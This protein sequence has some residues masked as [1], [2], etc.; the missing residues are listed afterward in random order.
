MPTLQL[1]RLA[2][3]LSRQTD[4]CLSAIGL[5]AAH[6]PVLAALKDGQ[7]KTQKELATIAGVEQPSMAQLLNR[8]ERDGLIV[9]TASQNDR[10]SSLVTL[11]S[12]GCDR[13]EPGRDVLRRIDA[14]VCAS[15]SVSDRETL[16]SLLNKLN[17]V[18]G[19]R[20]E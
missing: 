2:R 14:E 6:L 20:E 19:T 8:M 4:Q 11:S 18:R 12:E 1:E 15:L 3:L 7:A 13:L 16:V 5:R 17:E 9:R 10:R